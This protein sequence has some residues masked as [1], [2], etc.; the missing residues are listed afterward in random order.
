MPTTTFFNLPA[1]KQHR[2][3][4]AARREF[5]RVPFDEASINRIVRDAEISR[6]SFYMYFADKG[7]LFRFLL[8]HHTRRICDLVCGA[9][10]EAGGDLFAAFPAVYDGIVRHLTGDPEPALSDLIAIVQVNAASHPGLLANELDLS[11]LLAEVLPRVDRARL[12]LRG[13]HDL[14][15]IL[16]LLVQVTVSATMMC[17]CCSDL[18]PEQQRKR[19]LDLLDLLR[20]G[21]QRQTKPE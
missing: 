16:Q 17:A 10:E 11:A 21:M 14:E 5:G 3:L 20:R 6:G 13:A 2:L 7:D 4:T 1:E 18:T 15:L 12:D 9:L 8:D 19:Y